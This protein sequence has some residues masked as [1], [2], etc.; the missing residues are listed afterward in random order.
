MTL[1]LNAI[2]CRRH[3]SA[4]SGA[5]GFLSNGETF[6]SISERVLT[7]RSISSSRHKLRR[8]NNSMYSS[9]DR[10]SWKLA[11]E[12]LLQLRISPV[13]SAYGPGL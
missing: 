11:S 9:T 5:N 12:T 4:Y 7:A 3:E 6:L 13:V 2:Q 1:R 8:E 10:W